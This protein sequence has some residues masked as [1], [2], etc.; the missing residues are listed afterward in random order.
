M[1]SGV[2][3]TEFAVHQTGQDMFAA[4]ILHAGKPVVPVKD[5]THLRSDRDLSVGQIPDV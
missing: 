4:V 2:I 3:E 5:A 1:K